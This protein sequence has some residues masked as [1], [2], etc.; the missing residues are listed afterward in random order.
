[1]TPGQRCDVRRLTLRIWVLLWLVLVWILL[2]GDVSAAN[3]CRGLAIAL[4]ITLLL[5]L[6]PVP[7]EGR[8]HPISLLRLIVQ[9]AWYLVL[10]STQ[11][12]WLAIRPGPPPL[13][14]GAA[15]PAWTSS[16]IWCWRW[17]STSS[18]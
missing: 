11:V 5:P 16:R 18:T 9:V 13:T 6:P 8:V 12:A 2:W 4:V 17:R 3:V 14:R 7:V 15:G 10:S 1:M